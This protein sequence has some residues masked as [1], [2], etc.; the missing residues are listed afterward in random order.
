MA[1]V[2]LQVV[3][4]NDNSPVFEP[5]SLHRSLELSEDAATGTVLTTLQATDLDKVGGKVTVIEDS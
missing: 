4:T 5:S 2:S 3:D 1:S